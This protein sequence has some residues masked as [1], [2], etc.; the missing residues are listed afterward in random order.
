MDNL[1][2]IDKFWE[3]YNLQVWTG[4]KQKIWTEKLPKMKLNQ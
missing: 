1:E 3:K 4:K 2:E